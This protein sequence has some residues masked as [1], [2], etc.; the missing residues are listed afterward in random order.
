MILSFEVSPV[1]YSDSDIGEIKKYS[2]ALLGFSG[3][4]W[5]FYETVSEVT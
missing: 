2:F 5:L 1:N 4:N 3:L